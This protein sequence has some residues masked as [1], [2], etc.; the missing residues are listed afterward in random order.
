MRLL[1]SLLT[2][3]SF[4]LH[5]TAISFA[6]AAPECNRPGKKILIL[7]FSGPLPFI[8]PVLLREYLSLEKRF[9]PLPIP[10]ESN[11]GGKSAPYFLKGAVVREGTGYRMSAQIL[12]GN[13][14]QELSRCEGVFEFPQ[15]LNEFLLP[16]VEK[17][18]ASLGKK[19]TEKKILPYLNATRSGQAY[20][21]YAE[22]S[23]YLQDLNVDG[24]KKAEEAF[25]RA[26]K[27]D[28]NYV[29]AYLGLA[30]ALA[31]ESLIQ[32][33][34]AGQDGGAG[35]RARLEITKAKLLNP[36]LTKIKES[37]IES[38]LKADRWN[39]CAEEK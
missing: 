11:A 38:F 8:I 29:P 1:L 31:A 16:C 21:A 23:L 33:T 32:R 5:D 9:S 13:S 3:L 34:G 19:L 20:L 2:I 37:R 14:G 17:F 26:I 10:R 30:E 27:Q 22:G 15:T 12:T 35:K 4:H 36:V 6:S 18:S 24:L 39:V 25:E 28:Y 7:P